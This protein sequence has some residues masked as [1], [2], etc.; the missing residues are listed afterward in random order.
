[1]KIFQKVFKDVLNVYHTIMSSKIDG[2]SNANNRLPIL[3][4]SFISKDFSSI[5]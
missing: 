3:A 1:M 5:H 2:F 4:Q